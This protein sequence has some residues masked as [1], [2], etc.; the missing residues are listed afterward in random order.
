MGLRSALGVKTIR[1]SHAIDR[2]YAKYQRA[3]SSLITALAS[4]AT[5]D[6]FNDETYS[7]AGVYKPG[8]SYTRRFLFPW[9][10]SAIRAH[11]PGPPARILIGG[12]GAGRE[13]FA[14]EDMG[15]D[16]VAFEPVPALVAE[17]AGRAA[18]GSRVRALTGR[19]QDLPRLTE[20]GAKVDVPSLG[21]FDA[22]I[23]GWGSMSYL[24]TPAERVGTMQAVSRLTHGPV[25]MSFTDVTGDVVPPQGRLG[26]WRHRRM[27][28]LGRHPHDFFTPT[29]GYIHPFSELELRRLLDQTGFRMLAMNLS[30]DDTLAPHAVVIPTAGQSPR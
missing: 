10:E 14:L 6:R 9:E 12:A 29:M 23:L 24:R 25:L 5:L 11:F 8:G 13:A 7:A 30:Q 3:R 21:P 20:H 28:R 15:Y 17:M 2:V 4:D 18:E 22:V 19:Y 26:R 1:A 16:I 27:Q